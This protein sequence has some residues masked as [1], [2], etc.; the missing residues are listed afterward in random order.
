MAV[1]DNGQGTCPPNRGRAFEMLTR[2][3]GSDAPGTGI[4][5][6]LCRTIVERHGGRIWGEAKKSGQ[7]TTFHFTISRT[8]EQV[9]CSADSHRTDLGVSVKL[10]PEAGRPNGPQYTLSTGEPMYQS[11]PSVSL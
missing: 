11:F 3:H 4:G 1:T 5:L 6:A 2:L 7:G 9:S 8:E 10:C